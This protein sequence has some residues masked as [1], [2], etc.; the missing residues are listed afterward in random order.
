MRRWPIPIAASSARVRGAVAY[1]FHLVEDLPL[2]TDSTVGTVVFAPATHS[3]TRVILAVSN[4]AA[5]LPHFLVHTRAGNSP[6]AVL[7]YVG[8][9]ADEDDI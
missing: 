7:V 2:D 8:N 1:D 9:K 5:V 3:D 4:S 6:S